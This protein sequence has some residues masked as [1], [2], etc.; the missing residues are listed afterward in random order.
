MDFLPMLASQLYRTIHSFFTEPLASAMRP[1]SSHPTSL[2]HDRTEHLFFC[3]SCQKPPWTFQIR[4]SVGGSQA[5]IFFRGTSHILLIIPRSIQSWKLLLGLF[6]S[7]RHFSASR[8]HLSGETYY[9]I[10]ILFV[11]PSWELMFFMPCRPLWHSGEDCGSLLRMMFSHA[12][13]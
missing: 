4:T 8:D 3:D 13:S 5:L 12:Y 11:G 10:R 7:L 6:A 2:L 1:R 9:S